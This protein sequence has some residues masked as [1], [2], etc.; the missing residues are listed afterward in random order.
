MKI[1]EFTC[2]SRAPKQAVRQRNRARGIVPKS[3]PNH[4]D[5]SPGLPTPTREIVRAGNPGLAGIQPLTIFL[6][7]RAQ[8]LLHFAASQLRIRL[9]LENPLAPKQSSSQ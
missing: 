5:W 6:T 7:L 9:A 2:S 3:V 4:V 1:K 8:S